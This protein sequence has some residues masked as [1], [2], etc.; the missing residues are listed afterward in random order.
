MLGDDLSAG[1]VENEVNVDDV[2]DL[3][4][5][6]GADIVAVCSSLNSLDLGGFLGDLGDSIVDSLKE[7]FKFLL[8]GNVGAGLGS[9]LNSFF[10]A[11]K[12]C[13]LDVV[14]VENDGLLGF[15]GLDRSESLDVVLSAGGNL[16][17]SL[18]LFGSKSSDSLLSLVVLLEAL[19]ATLGLAV[20]EADGDLLFGLL[21]LLLL[22]LDGSLEALVLSDS[23]SFLSSA[24]ASE[25]IFLSLDSL[26]IL[27]R[28]GLLGLDGDLELLDFDGESLSG[29]GSSDGSSAFA[30]LSVL[31]ADTLGE[32]GFKRAD[33]AGLHALF[34][35]DSDLSKVFE[36]SLEALF[37]FGHL[38]GGLETAAN[39]DSGLFLWF[40]RAVD[41][42]GEGY[43]G[44]GE[45]PDNDG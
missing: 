6:G 2:Q 13:G 32:L 41:C 21:L 34:K 16:H 8:L 33:G 45:Q 22:T 30:D 42:R 9:L 26:G 1:S 3:A 23:K 44:D 28:T 4:E 35:L 27:I 15:D 24:E 7:L 37:L 18:G 40:H 20:L 36:S 39:N 19:G 29:V 5:S 31:L 12:I 25:S 38:S 11:F 14:S 43:A 17:E 10:Q